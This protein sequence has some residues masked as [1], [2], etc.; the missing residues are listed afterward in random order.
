MSDTN[1][2]PR[3]K[4]R[5]GRLGYYLFL[6]VFTVAII[7]I[8]ARWYLGHVLQKS[9]S[10]K[11]RFNSYRVY[12]HVP[13]FREGDG[14]R[15]W[16]VINNHGFRRDSDVP[17][18]KAPGTKRVFFLGGSAAHGISSSAPY[19]VV[20]I[21]QDQTVDAQLERM[22]RE[23]MP[24][25]RV[26]VI[27]AAVTG[28]QVFQHTQ[29]LLTELLAYD[30]DLVIFFDGQNDHYVNNPQYRY[31]TDFRY[32]FWKPLLQ[33]PGAGTTWMAFANW[34][35]RYSGAFRG[36]VAWRMTR[37][38]V[39]EGDRVDWLT[40]HVDDETTIAN[41]RK[42]ARDQ[43]LRAID[44]NLFLL[45]RDSVKAVVCLQPQ[46]MLRDST[47]LSDQER[48]FMRPE[49]HIR[50]LYPVVL[51]ELREVTGRW[52]VPLVDMMPA[53]NQP[54]YR[55]QQLLI[56]YCHLSPLGGEACAKALLPVVKVALWPVTA[57]TLTAPG[58]PGI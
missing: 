43:F 55:G 34:M 10:N 41:H 47:L 32:Q 35:S 24:D 19:P 53:I 56:D 46:L 22:L 15:D 23:A 8:G 30:P 42:V 51:Q 31:M 1:E 21:Y 2:T 11:F 57:D 20:H 5:W 13:G 58:A 38:A 52:H 9:S 49:G 45:T 44:D 17:M 12:E 33:D 18:E 37:D 36:Y 40:P 4:S 16:I 50:A 25:E 14:E 48:S 6:L 3:R 54:E 39:K 7:E 28:Y 29:Y 27:N 26:E